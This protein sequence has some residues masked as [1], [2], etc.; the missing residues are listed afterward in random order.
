MKLVDSCFLFFVLSSN[1]VCCV[2]LKDKFTKLFHSLSFC[3]ASFSIL[4][5]CVEKSEISTSE[6]NEGIV[7]SAKVQVDDLVTDI[8]ATIE[9]VIGA[10]DTSQIAD[11]VKNFISNE[12]SHCEIDTPS[13]LSPKQT[14]TVDRESEFKP[15]DDAIE[16]LKTEVRGLDEAAAQY[17]V[18]KQP[19]VARKP[20]DAE[21]VGIADPEKIAA[22]DAAVANLRNEARSLAETSNV[23]RRGH[24]YFDYSLYRAKSNSPPP[25]PLNTYRWEDLKRDREKVTFI[26]R[27]VDELFALFSDDFFGLFF[28]FRRVVIHGRI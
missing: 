20:T 25:H 7:D 12:K 16:K 19:T 9:K 8:S 13:L 4:E 22:L 26:S 15:L 14:K 5:S 23:K 11:E 2:L 6:P 28:R 18:S 3:C 21:I 10:C 17:K 24:E 27:I 1:I